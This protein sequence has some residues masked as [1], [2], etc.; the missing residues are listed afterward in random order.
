MAFFERIVGSK[1]GVVLTFNEE[2]EYGSV[3]VFSVVAFGDGV[4]ER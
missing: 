4:L 3:V 1:R 2:G